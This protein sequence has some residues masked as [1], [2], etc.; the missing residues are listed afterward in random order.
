MVNTE[1]ELNKFQKKFEKAGRKLLKKLDTK[2]YIKVLGNYQAVDVTEQDK[3]LIVTTTYFSNIST[4]RTIVNTL[5]TIKYT[6]TTNWCEQ[7]VIAFMEEVMDLYLHE[8]DDKYI[9]EREKEISL[10]YNVPTSRLKT[11]LALFLNNLDKGTDKFNILLYF[12]EYEILKWKYRDI[13]KLQED[14][15]AGKVNSYNLYLLKRLDYIE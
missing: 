3:D 4:R 1:K 13:T 11:Q 5:K 14:I 6:R 8:G 12:S 2:N 10:R 7:V 9:K 15:E